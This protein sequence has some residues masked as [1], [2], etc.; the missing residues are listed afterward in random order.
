MNHVSNLS[1][2]ALFAAGHTLPMPPRKPLP[3]PARVPPEP[4]HTDIDRWVFEQITRI[5]AEVMVRELELKPDPESAVRAQAWARS[6]L[7][8]IVAASNL[9][10]VGEL[11]PEVPAPRKPTPFPRKTEPEEVA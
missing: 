5:H 1:G 9:I 3:P 8:E 6:R 2:A 7:A 11:F 10:V 4:T